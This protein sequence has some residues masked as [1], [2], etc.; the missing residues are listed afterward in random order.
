MDQLLIE[1]AI[2]FQNYLMTNGLQGR[3]QFTTVF[4]STGELAAGFLMYWPT[5]IIN[6]SKF[7]Q[8]RIQFLVLQTTIAP[9]NELD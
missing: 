4:K 1:Y 5:K 2:H 7:L 6:P 3:T 9:I 8:K